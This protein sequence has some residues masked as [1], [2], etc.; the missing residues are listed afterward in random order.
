LSEPSKYKIILGFAAIYII[1][2]STYLA[3]RLGVESLPPFLMAGLRFL[4]GGLLLYGWARLAGAEAPKRSHWRPAATI[5]LLMAGG[6]TGLVTWAETTVPSGLAALLVA[7][8]PMWIV[9]ADWLRPGGARPTLIVISGLLLGFLGVAL[10]INPGDIVGVGDI[11]KLGAMVIVIATISWAIGSIYSRHAHQ[12]RSKTLGAGMQM[13]AG[14]AGLMIAAALTGE[15]TAFHV[16]GVA[17]RSWLALGYLITVGSAAFAVYIWL[18]AASTPAK[19]A[20]YAYV[21]PVIALFLGY[22]VAG[23]TLDGRVLAC[24][25]V[26]ITAVFIIIMAR[27]RTERHKRTAVPACQPSNGIKA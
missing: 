21:N 10:L 17:L 8:V 14:G 13:L 22:I 24:S 7:V 20:T 15:M 25:L 27:A 23:E 18:I 26:I 3:I 5:G 1:W 9:L 6:A 12:P 4:T 2:G 16:D 19:V 11:D